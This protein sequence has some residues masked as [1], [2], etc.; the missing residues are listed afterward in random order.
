MG[1]CRVCQVG[2]WFRSVHTDASIGAGVGTS[3]SHVTAD[4]TLPKMVDVSEKTATIR[5]A[6]A[7][8]TLILPLEVMQE[9]QQSSPNLESSTPTTS[10]ELKGPKG[11]VFATAIIAGVMGAKRTSDLIPFW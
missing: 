6:H 8:S 1:R 7:R 5:R 11:P 2:R 10:K 3:L 9:L 4:G